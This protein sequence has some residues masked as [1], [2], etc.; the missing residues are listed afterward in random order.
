MYKLL[1]ENGKQYLSKEKGLFGGN[2][3]LK[4]YQKNKARTPPLQK[5]F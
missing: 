4:I 1:D 2:K 5:I 3:T